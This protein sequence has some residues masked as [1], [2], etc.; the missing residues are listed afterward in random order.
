MYY[1]KQGTPKNIVTYQNVSEYRAAAMEFL[2]QRVRPI[3]IEEAERQIQEV[4]PEGLPDPKNMI[5][6]NIRWGDKA[7][8]ME[9][10]PI[11]RYIYAVTELLMDRPPPSDNNSTT[12]NSIHIYLASEDPA[13]ITAF[14][15]AAP[16]SWIIHHSGPKIVVQ[17]KNMLAQENANGQNGLESLGALLVSLESNGYV[18]TTGSNWSRLINELRKNVLNPRCDYCTKMIDLK[19]GEW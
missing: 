15:A 1:P 16:S 3:V 7:R 13:A 4:F 14:T 11:E 8:E 10:Q 18:L 2:F 6:V 9:L 19:Y 17:N 5:T 12:D